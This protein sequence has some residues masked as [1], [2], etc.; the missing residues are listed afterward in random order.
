MLKQIKIFWKLSVV[1]V[2]MILIFVMTVY[3]VNDL[4]AGQYS[5]Q[6]SDSE[7]TG[8]NLQM[9][10]T[11]IITIVFSLAAAAVF[12]R[13]IIKRPVDKMMTGMNK[14][15]NKEFDFRMEE[16]EKATSAVICGS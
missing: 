7:S 1:F 8:R 2:V 4:I 13:V 15:A 14:L 10:F 16:S 3:Y 11:L 9:I 6:G 12:V 5:G